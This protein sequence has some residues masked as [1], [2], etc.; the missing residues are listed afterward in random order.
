MQKIRTSELCGTD[1]DWAVAKCENLEI[2]IDQCVLIG[3]EYYTPSKDWSQGGP[4][5]EREG[6]AIDCERCGDRIDSWVA[7]LPW[8]EEAFVKASYGPTPLIA[9]MRCYVKNRLGETVK[10]PT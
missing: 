3:D 7:S 1:L 6:I 4:I 2:D 9:A 10:I 8:D 5:I